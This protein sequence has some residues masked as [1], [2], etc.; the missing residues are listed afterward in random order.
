VLALLLNSGC[1][2][3]PKEKTALQLVRDGNEHIAKASHNKLVEIRSEQSVGGL[4]PQVWYVVYYDED[5]TFK[6]TE[7]KFGGG[8]KMEVK[9]P[10]RVLEYV[11]DDRKPLDPA[12]IKVDSDEAIRVAAK[13]PL[14]NKLSLKATQLLL[15]KSSDGPVWRVRFW[16]QKVQRA[17][18]LAEIGDVY[19]STKSAKVVRTDLHIDRVN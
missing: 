17:D 2:G 1:G 16:A 7:V 9:R 5:A 18:E 11:T 4:E 6:A 3:A 10:L 8:K 19:V 15:Q 12:Q 13:E 14:L